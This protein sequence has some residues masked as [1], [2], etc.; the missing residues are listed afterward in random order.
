MCNFV[1]NSTFHRRR[2]VK[3]FYIIYLI[4]AEVFFGRGVLK[5]CSKFNGGHP[6]RSVISIKLLCNFIET[7]LR[8]GCT[9]L[10]SLLQLL[11]IAT[12]CISRFSFTNIHNSQDSR[13]KGRQLEINSFKKYL[14]YLWDQSQQNFS[15][16]FFSFFRFYYEKERRSYIRPKNFSYIQIYRW[17]NYHQ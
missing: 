10:N 3:S 11:E 13:R 1:C 9:L 2:M 6:C 8:Y 14:V 15:L 5:I 12:F 7:A 16:V 4:Y 17:S